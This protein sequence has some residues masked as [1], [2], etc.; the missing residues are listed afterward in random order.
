MQMITEF[1]SM[2]RRL[3]L[4]ITPQIKNISQCLGL[5]KTYRSKIPWKRGDFRVV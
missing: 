1:I 2:H 5:P 4:R 3:L